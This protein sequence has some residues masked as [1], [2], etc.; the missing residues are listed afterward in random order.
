MSRISINPWS[1]DG[2]RLYVGDFHRP[3]LHVVDCAAR[4]VVE[5]VPLTGVPGWPFCTPDG[6]FVMVEDVV[7]ETA[8]RRKPAIHITETWYEEFRG[9]E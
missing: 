9:R 3:L 8:S 1:A 4:K 5:T 6:R 2:A 7:D